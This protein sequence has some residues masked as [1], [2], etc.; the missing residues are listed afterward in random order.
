MP[1][2]LTTGT[3][4]SAPFR[5]VLSC[6]HRA[7]EG[8]SLGPQRA[9]REGCREGTHEADRALAPNAESCLG[10]EFQQLL[11]SSEQRTKRFKEEAAEVTSKGPVEKRQPQQK[12]GEGGAEPG[13]PGRVRTAGATGTRHPSPRPRHTASPNSP[14]FLFASSSPR[15]FS[16]C[17]RPARLKNGCH[18][19]F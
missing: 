19:P 5:L 16:S 12:G 17:S 14:V 10:Q 11:E 2:P 7:Q 1:S 8:P 6:I 15:N 4:K 3:P 18:H 13:P 9:S